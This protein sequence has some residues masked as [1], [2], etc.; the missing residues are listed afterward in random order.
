MVWRDKKKIIFV[1]IPKTGG[2]SIEVAMNS[3]YYRYGYGVIFTNEKNEFNE[4]R[5][6][7]LKKVCKMRN[8]DRMKKYAL[9]HFK[10]NEYKVLLGGDIYDKYF[11]FSIC[12]N[13]Y[14]RI[15]SEFFWCEIP[16][17]GD[18]HGQSFDD[19]LK[20]AKKC[21]FNNNYYETIYHDHF[22][23]QH[24]FI[25]DDKNNLQV[26]KLFKFENFNE[27]EFFLKED[28][29]IKNIPH[30]HKRSKSK[31]IEL[32]SKQKAKIYKMYKKDF[33]LLN[34]EK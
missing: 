13:P 25:Y 32:T 24:E 31:T 28:L 19:F 8:L 27:I 3:L 18:K 4:I 33:E 23:P 21:R 12:R 15:I 29:E 2:T 16:G 26:D 22:I 5:H 20:Y 30:W 17:I 7:N 9:Q 10:S 6:K 14:D 11:K 34:Y 1:H